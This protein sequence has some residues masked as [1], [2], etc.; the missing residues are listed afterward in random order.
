MFPGSYDT[1]YMEE[2]QRV[3]LEKL[4]FQS[5]SVDQTVSATTL[6]VTGT[7]AGLPSIPS[8]VSRAIVVNNGSQPIIYTTSPGGTP[9]AG[10]PIVGL[11]L[12][13]GQVI[14]LQAG[15]IKNFRVV[16]A[17]GTDS[18]LYIEYKQFVDPTSQYATYVPPT[19]PVSNVQTFSTLSQAQSAGLTPPASVYISSEDTY[20]DLKAGGFVPRVYSE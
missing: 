20:Y 14:E 12:G 17:A 16:R 15:D 2:R 8:L 10:P 6:A 19:N 18:S 13:D 1:N 3:L 5:Q 4:L 7:P 11:R 9:S